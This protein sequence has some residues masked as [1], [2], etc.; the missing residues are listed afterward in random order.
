MPQDPH[1]R[2]PRRWAPVRW[3]YDR[4]LRPRRTRRIGALLAPLLPAGGDVLDVGCGDGHLTAHLASLRR[5]LRFVG[6]EV[7]ARPREGLE[8]HAYDGRRLPFPD[9]SFDT[10]L[11]CAVLHHLDEPGVLLAEAARVARRHIVL[12]D[13]QV[14]RPLDRAL[15]GLVDWPGNVPFGVYTPYA[16]LSRDEWR[17]LFD[18]LGLRLEAFDDR[19]G[20]FGHGV[21]ERLFGGRTHFT[22]R[23][24]VPP[25]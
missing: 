7:F 2:P 13:H 25:G 9:R 17:A 22:C 21:L 20:L 11:M 5:D 15:L 6:V 18:R 23:L 19:I 10:V 4:L 1:A 24:A 8:L 16:F 14:E 3:A 12:L